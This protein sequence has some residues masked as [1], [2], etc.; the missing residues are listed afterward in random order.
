VAASASAAD[1]PPATLWQTFGLLAGDILGR[2]VDVGLGQWANDD[3]CA[4]EFFLSRSRKRLHRRRARLAGIGAALPCRVN[5]RLLR[6]G[7]PVHPFFKLFV[8]LPPE[9]RRDRQ[10]FAALEAFQ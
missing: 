8:P 2:V 6:F 1:L 4:H 9:F 7:R 3:A 5:L 10:R